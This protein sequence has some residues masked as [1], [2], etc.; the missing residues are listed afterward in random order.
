[1]HHVIFMWPP[2][3]IIGEVMSETRETD[4]EPTPWHLWVI[5]VVAL[6]YIVANNRNDDNGVVVTTVAAPNELEQV[7][8]DLQETILADGVVTRDELVQAVAAMATCLK[9]HGLTG[10]TW[11]VDDD[12]NSWEY[13]YESDDSDAER[14]ISNLC[15]FSYVD[16]LF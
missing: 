5:G 12:G 16:R 2:V 14:A 15:F 9:D 4:V 10:V 7:G 6:I 13:E 1:M 3:G 8:V 11:S